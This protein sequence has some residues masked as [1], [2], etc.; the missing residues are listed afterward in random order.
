MRIIFTGGGTGGHIYP[1]VAVARKILENKPQTDVLFLSGSKEIERRI[2]NDAGFDV[3]SMPVRGMPRKLSPALI[4][5]MMNL[6]ISIVKSAQIIRGFRPSVIM[7]TGGY[8]SGPPIL[9]GRAMGVP[10]IIQE[11]NS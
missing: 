1:A 2:I 10:V 4:P 9:A 8:V 5:F 3:K 7:A 6:G 11:Q